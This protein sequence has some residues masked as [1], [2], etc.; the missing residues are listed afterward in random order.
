MRRG[1]CRGRSREPL[2]GSAQAC[3]GQVITVQPLMVNPVLI[4]YSLTPSHAVDS[5]AYVAGGGRGA[6]AP[7]PPRGWPLRPSL[8]HVRGGGVMAPSEAERTSAA[9]LAKTPLA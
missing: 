6:R 7:R 2:L 9:Y 3:R 4:H 8:S 5:A 1:S